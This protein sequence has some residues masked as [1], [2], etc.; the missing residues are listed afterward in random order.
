MPPS[1]GADRIGVSLGSH[2]PTVILKLP[3]LVEKKRTKISPNAIHINSTNPLVDKSDDSA[4]V[5]NGVSRLVDLI[6]R[7]QYIPKGALVIFDGLNKE[8][9]VGI[10]LVVIRIV[11]LGRKSGWLFC[12]FYFKQ[13]ASSLMMAYGGDEFVHPDNAVPVSLTRSGYPRIIPSHHRRM[14]LKKD[15]KADMLRLLK[16][17]HH[18]FAEVLRRIPMDDQTAPLIRLVPSKTCLSYDLKS[19]TDWWPLVFLFERLALL[20]DRSFASSVVNTTLGTNV[21]EVPFVKRA[22]SQVSF[23]TGQPLGYY[24]YWP[25]FA[26]THHV[27]VWWAAEQVRPGILFDRYAILGDDVLITDPL[28]AEQ[29]RLGLQRLGVKISTHKSLISSTGAVE[30]AKQFL[31]KDMRVNLSPVSMKALCGF[32]HPHGYYF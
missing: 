15:E 17:I 20:F 4:A 7:G 8:L 1:W 27:L 11:H 23:V 14:I 26:F 19:A 13:A 22:L 25:L 28:V 30:F 9:C 2:R 16:P 32:H 5:R 29:Y 6:F 21:F 18:W 3:C 10:H 12:A 24:G 31:V